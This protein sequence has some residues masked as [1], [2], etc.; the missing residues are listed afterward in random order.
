MR[1]IT[2]PSVENADEDGLVAVG[3]DLEADMLLAAY[4]QGIFPWP[5]SVDLPLAWFSPDPR[6]VIDLHEFHL[7]KS[8][9]KWQ[10]K[11]N[12]KVTVNKAFQ[13]VIK[14]CAIV[15]RKNQNSTWITPQLMKGYI[16]F[17]EQKYAYSIEVWN[18]EKLV[19]GLF[20]VH[21][22]DFVSGESMFS[23]ETNASKLAL[24]FV[25]TNL[26]KDG[27]KYLDTQMVTPVVESFG[28]KEIDRSDFIHYINSLQWEQSPLKENWSLK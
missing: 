14:N 23:T 21:I 24:F 7:P 17:H 12:L 15:K 27:L 13:E 18:D 1:Q 20:G 28:G 6:G 16:K 2:F 22:G 9:L 8:F 5:I 25:I 11:T 26:K 4:R 3:G 10:R 19:G